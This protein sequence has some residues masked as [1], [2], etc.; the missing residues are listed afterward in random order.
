MPDET[1]GHFNNGVETLRRE[2]ALEFS[3]PPY[4]IQDQRTIERVDKLA[5]GLILPEHAPAVPAPTV[6]P[7]ADPADAQPKPAAPNPRDKHLAGMPT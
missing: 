4:S 1:I 2:I 3:K 6:E 7:E 5:K